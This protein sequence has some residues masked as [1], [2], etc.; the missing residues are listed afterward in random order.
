M[1][2]QQ[3]KQQA[4]LQQHFQKQQEE[5]LER[6]RQQ[7]QQ[8]QLQQQRHQEYMKDQEKLQGW[9]GSTVSDEKENVRPK[10]QMKAWAT[11]SPHPP[12]STPSVN[13]TQQN[14]VTHASPYS[15]KNTHT[16][17][18]VT[19]YDTPVTNY[20][21]VNVSN[22]SAVQMTAT[23]QPVHS[24]PSQHTALQ[25]KSI[26]QET[27]ATLHGAQ[28]ASQNVQTGAKTGTDKNLSFLETVTNNLDQVQN[29][30]AS[31][32][33]TRTNSDRMVQ[34][35]TAHVKSATE[36]THAKSVSEPKA[37]SLVKTVPSSPKVPAYQSYYLNSYAERYNASKVPYATE[38]T[39][40]TESGAADGSI[41]KGTL[42]LVDGQLSVLPDGQITEEGADTADTDSVSTLCEDREPDIKGEI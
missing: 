9:G 39:T 19:T 38:T 26:K 7:Q 32:A 12:A 25:T 35:E 22:A 24:L 20:S 36:N 40:T 15:G 13:S 30:D 14:F 2:E 6:Q 37:Q 11:P 23:V 8:L 5:H 42:G 31:S 33:L 29:S 18:T 28:N 41:A 1:L 34:Y 4:L 21:A 27:N 10:V 3:Q 16:N 17:V